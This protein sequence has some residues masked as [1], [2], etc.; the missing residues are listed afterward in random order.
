MAHPYSYVSRVCVYRFLALLFLFSTLLPV[1]AQVCNRVAYHDFEDPAFMQGWLSTDGVNG[2]PSGLSRTD[3]AVI[4]GSYAAKLEVQGAGAS[5]NNR[6]MNFALQAGKFYTLSFWTRASDSAKVKFGILKDSTFFPVVFDSTEVLSGWQES[7]V[8]FEAPAD[9][10]NS[11]LVFSPVFD[12]ARGPYDFFLDFITLCE[13]D[14]SDTCNMADLPG[15]ES[16]AYTS[17]W[18]HYD[19][20]EPG[21]SFLFLENEDVYAGR[22]SGKMQ[23]NYFGGSGSFLTTTTRS[24]FELD[25]NSYYTFSCWMKSDVDSA[26][27]RA[28]V[29][30]RTPYKEFNTE[31]FI[32]DTVWRKYTMSFQATEPAPLAYIRFIAKNAYLTE[33]YNIFFDDMRLCKTDDPPPIAPGGVSRGLLFWAKANDGPNGRAIR[34]WEDRSPSENDLKRSGSAPLRRIDLL[35]QNEAVNFNSANDRLLSGAIPLDSRVNAHAW[36]V[37]LKGNNPAPRATPLAFFENGYRL[38]TDANN[39]YVIAGTQPAMMTPLSADV[40]SWNILSINSSPNT[41]R[42]YLNGRSLPTSSALTGLDLGDSTVVGAKAGDNTDWWNGD[43]AEIIVYRNTQSAADRYRINT[44]LSLKY[45]IS[46]PVNQHEHYSYNSHPQNLAGIG[47]DDDLMGLKQTKSKSIQAGSIVSVSR[48]TRLNDGDYLV[49]GHNNGALSSSTQIPTGVRSRV[50]R[51]WRVSHTGDVGKVTVSFDLAELGLPA[52]YGYTLLIDKDGNFSNAESFGNPYVN[53]AEVGFPGVRLE[54]G[55]YFT[56]GQVNNGSIPKAPGLIDDGLSLWLQADEGPNSNSLSSWRDLS[57]YA[58]SATAFDVGPRREWDQINGNPAID[59]TQ[60]RNMMIGAS[61][62][63]L[64]PSAHSYYIMLDSRGTRNW[65]NPFTPRES[66]YRLEIN[67]TSRNYSI[68]GLEPGG[69]N[70]TA[71]SAGWSMISI[72]ARSDNYEIYENGEMNSSRSIRDG[73]QGEGP[74]VVGARNSRYGGW[75]IGKI[76]EV[77]VFAKEQDAATR[78]AV[79][80]YMAMKYGFTL[81]VSSHLYYN[82]DSHP[83]AIAGIGKDTQ[84]RLWQDD[85]KS[86]DSTAIVRINNPAGLG[87]G[88][89]LVW[90]HDGDTLGRSSNVP[91]NVNTR[92]TRSWKVSQTGNPGSVW[93]EFELGGLG[94][95]L[96]DESAFALLIDKDTDFSDA[97]VRNNGVFVGSKLIFKGIQ[98][99]DGNTF[100]LAVD[101]KATSIDQDLPSKLLSWKLYPNPGQDFLNLAFETQKPAKLRVQ[102]FDFQG[103]VLLQKDLENFTMSQDLRVST[104]S[105]PEGMYFVRLSEGAIS[106]SKTW[107]KQR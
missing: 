15:F 80:T 87:E 17:A 91:P 53:E 19:G 2:I 30:R 86:L 13:K 29:N 79:E 28:M 72:S 25:S 3:S 39:Q 21:S 65:T 9:W 26:R 59:F 105:W 82:H 61:D 73:L 45:G 97:D 85:S 95:S 49:W 11:V 70:S 35:N 38:A 16:L 57:R 32:L 18:S 22:F 84:Q 1:S 98:F 63:Y 44:Y 75:F 107:L 69:I 23:V 100:S 5:M 60:F 83:Y 96:S 37:V 24:Y 56:L 7:S 20:G 92:F 76:A 93:V 77:V 88:E 48:P 74:Y 6:P 68:Y 106:L 71:P 66:G 4:S 90:G 55:D 89:Y 78:H 43:I 46:I 8:E 47:Q 12:A 33:P 99:Q 64:S 94:I 27:I 10:P 42:P 103:R 102:I 14:Q 36:Y 104:A 31:Y 67:G 34:T 58:N 41:F 54:D 40:N 62:L 50:T 52:G 101:N 81:P 51:T